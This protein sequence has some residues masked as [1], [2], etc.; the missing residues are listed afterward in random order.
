M[1]A[2]RGRVHGAGPHWHWQGFLGILAAA[3]GRSQA[4]PIV[5]AMPTDTRTHHGYAP[6]ERLRLKRPNV[7]L[8]WLNFICCPDTGTSFY[9]VSLN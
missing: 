2:R 3:G 5:Q 8:F 1:S 9:K 4:F 7:P 6:F